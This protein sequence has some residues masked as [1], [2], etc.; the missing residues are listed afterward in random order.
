M[1]KDFDDIPLSESN[2]QDVEVRRVLSRLKR[3]SSVVE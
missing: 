2:V 1:Q 3:D